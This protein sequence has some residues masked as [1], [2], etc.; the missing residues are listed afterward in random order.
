MD[1]R[2]AGF[3][4][5]EMRRVSLALAFVGNPR[6]VF[7]DEPTTGLDSDTQEAFQAAARDYVAM[8]GALV[9]TSHQWDDIETICSKIALIDQGESVLSGDIASI[10]ERIY[11]N[12]IRFRLS[13]DHALP[14]WLAASRDGNDVSLDATE[15][16][17]ILK[18][19]VSE[20]VPFSSLTIEPLK[21][22][23]IIR[24]IRAE[25]ALQ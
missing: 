10:R 21:L 12:R 24:R 20:A 14:D 3:S 9:L 4:G 23:D 13:N 18:R 17:T 8:G 19:M 25:E 6:L 11:G 5:G 7:L 2:V 22:K 1:R 15:S 16:D